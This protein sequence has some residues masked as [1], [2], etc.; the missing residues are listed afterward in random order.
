[1]L[2]II[3]TAFEKRSV[4]GIAL[5]LATVQYVDAAGLES[6]GH[7]IS[8]G[9]DQFDQTW[10]LAAIYKT[11]A[12]QNLANHNMEL[13]IGVISSSSDNEVFVSFGPTWRW[14]I[15]KQTVYLDFGFSPTVVSG[16]TFDDHDVGGNLHFTSSLALG[17]RFGRDDDFLVSL[18]LQHTSNGGL[19]STN[20]GLDMVGLNIQFGRP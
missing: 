7:R 17:A 10:Q 20:P 5:I 16:S 9:L 12:S 19:A 2:A 14:P 4:C 6:A 13:A 8:S 3:N 1:M 11:G 15:H 18:R